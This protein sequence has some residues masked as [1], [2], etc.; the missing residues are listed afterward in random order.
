M[1]QPELRDIH[2]PDPLSWWPPAIGWWL[3]VIGSLALVAQRSNP[4]RP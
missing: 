1:N 4:Q 3:L 2:L